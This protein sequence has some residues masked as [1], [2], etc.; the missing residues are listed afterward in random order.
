MAVQIPFEE[1][2]ILL[3]RIYILAK[4]V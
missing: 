2:L 3:G 4:K 1:Y